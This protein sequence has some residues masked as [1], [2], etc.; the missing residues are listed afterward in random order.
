VLLTVLGMPSLAL[1]KGDLQSPAKQPA[2]VT[3]SELYHT[4]KS[5]PVTDKRVFTT[6]KK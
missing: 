4:L 6:L 3:H 1:A 5:A 2:A